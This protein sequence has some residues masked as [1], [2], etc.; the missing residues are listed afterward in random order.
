MGCPTDKQI[1]NPI[2]PLNEYIADGE[3]H[4]FGDRVY[5]F[6]S[7]DKEG[8]ET[9][10]MLDYVVYSAPVNNVKD[11]RCDGTVYCAKQDPD[12]S[13]RYK[14]MYAPD[15]VKG[16]DGQYY[17]YY[18]M[19]GGCFTGPIHVAVCNTPAGKY[20]YYGCVR[21]QDGAPYTRHVTFDP[22]VLND[23]GEIWLYYGWAL[24]IDESRLPKKFV[25]LASKLIKGMLK[26][27]ESRMFDKTKEEVKNESR[28]VMGANVVRL[29]DDMLT[30]ISE[31]S[32]IVPGQFDSMKTSFFGHAFFEAN[33][34]RKIGGTYYFIYSSENQ[35]ELCYA[36][37]KYPDRDFVYGGTI[38][39]GGEIGYKGRKATNRLNV[40]GNNHGSVERVNGEWYVFYHRHTH[41]SLYSRQACAEKITVMLDGQIPQV[42]V[43]SQGLNGG[44][45]VAKGCYPAAI[46]CNLTNGHMPHMMNGFNRKP[47]PHVTH[48][49]KE[50]F[51][52]EIGDGTMI[53]YKYFAFT[54]K[55]ILCLRFRGGALGT[56]SILADDDLLAKMSV[57]P[58]AGWTVAEALVEAR[59][60]K[61]LYFKFSGK[62]S[63][64]FISFEFAN[65]E[66]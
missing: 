66:D 56:L 26:T 39:S 32:R 44:P 2:F 62:G 51:I 27:L 64:D 47:M 11:W 60:I 50:R 65:K 10:C 19:A 15:V 35:H 18:A 22:G 28:G 16:V 14:Y 59:G 13:D 43:T 53:G 31:P 45:L 57:K 55:A 7:H 17:L 29:A 33:S 54:G 6:G 1:Y 41:K 61:A 49:G 30:V 48:Q 37:S 58:S 20:E 12:F 23:S 21:N 24:G 40:T 46:A 42:E 3:P 63:L 38:I 52:A 9:F 4:V 25:P 36:T 8:G 5:L 34:I